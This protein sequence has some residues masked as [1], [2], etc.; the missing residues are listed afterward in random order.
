MRI[1]DWLA[2]WLVGNY[3]LVGLAYAWDGQ[4][5]RVVYW[6]GAVLIVTATVRM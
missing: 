2:Y 1:G 6:L 3:I 4:W 5:W